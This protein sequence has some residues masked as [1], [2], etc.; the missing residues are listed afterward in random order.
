MD[1]MPRWKEMIGRDSRRERRFLVESDHPKLLPV[2]PAMLAATLGV[3]LKGVKWSEVDTTR[4][5]K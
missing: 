2:R 3:N 4:K 5:R 1:G